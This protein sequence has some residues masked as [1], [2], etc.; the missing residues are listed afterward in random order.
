MLIKIAASA[1]RAQAGFEAWILRQ[2]KMARIYS[3]SESD[4]PGQIP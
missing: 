4:M 1:T 2:P 3:C